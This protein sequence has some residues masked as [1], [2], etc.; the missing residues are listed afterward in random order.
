MEGFCSWRRPAGALPAAVTSFRAE[1]TRQGGRACCEEGVLEKPLHWPRGPPGDPGA[2]SDLPLQPSPGSPLLWGSP[3]PPS[4]PWHPCH[5]PPSGV[6]SPTLP[7]LW[8]EPPQVGVPGVPP[9]DLGV[10][11]ET[12][13]RPPSAGGSASGAAQCEVM[14]TPAR[15]AGS[16]GVTPP[17]N[18]LVPGPGECWAAASPEL[19]RQGRAS[20]LLYLQGPPP[21]PSMYQL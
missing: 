12:R 7:H 19:S 3:G 4:L 9:S 10:Q 5:N 11:E 20:R 2:D 15:H 14:M 8:E 6:P 18:A 21:S 16:T 17:V 13:Q 1:R